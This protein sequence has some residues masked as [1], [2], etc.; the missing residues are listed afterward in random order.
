MISGTFSR[1]FSEG[2]SARFRGIPKVISGTILERFGEYVR[3]ELGSFKIIRKHDS[4]SPSTVP[5]ANDGKRYYRGEFP[6]NRTFESRKLSPEPEFVRKR[7]HSFSNTPTYDVVSTFENE[8]P[9]KV[10]NSLL[11]KKDTEK[12]RRCTFRI[13]DDC[14]LLKIGNYI[15]VAPK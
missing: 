8:I 11:L 3:G 10:E 4:G 6:R 15:L 14:I 12:K 9:E 13:L 2:L 5:P 7:R 1:G